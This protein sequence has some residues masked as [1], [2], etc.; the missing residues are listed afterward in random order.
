M[1]TEIDILQNKLENYINIG[2]RKANVTM[3][4]IID[5]KLAL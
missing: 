1:N 5:E 4:K 3:R 2:E